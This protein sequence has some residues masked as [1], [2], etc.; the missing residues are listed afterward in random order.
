MMRVAGPEDLAHVAGA[1]AL[2]DFVMAKR[3]EHGT[4]TII[5]TR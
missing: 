1:E 3:L 2:E 4:A 5:L